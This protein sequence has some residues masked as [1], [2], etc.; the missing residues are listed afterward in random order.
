MAKYQQIKPSP[1][2]RYDVRPASHSHQQKHPMG[3]ASSSAT[4]HCTNKKL[5]TKGIDEHL[6]P[7]EHHLAVEQK[8]IDA[9]RSR[10]ANKQNI[11]NS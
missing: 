1:G 6:T 8:Y 11:T 2:E 4:D 3:E 7:Q 5:T 9:D 10:A